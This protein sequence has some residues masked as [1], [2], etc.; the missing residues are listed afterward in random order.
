M[1]ELAPLITVLTQ[2]LDW[3]RARITFLAQLLVAVIRVRT[4]N[5]TEM[6]TAF[7]GLPTTVSSYRRIQ[8]FF[9]AFVIAP[10]I[11]PTLVVRL[12][13][14]TLTSRTTGYEPPVVRIDPSN[15]HAV[16]VL[17]VLYALS[18]AAIIPGTGAIV[19][20]HYETSADVV[21]S[22]L[23]LLR[24][25]RL[26]AITN[27]AL[28]VSGDNGM[29]STDARS[30]E[31]VSVTAERVVH[32]NSLVHTRTNERATWHRA[33]TAVCTYI[34]EDKKALPQVSTPPG[35][36]EPTTGVCWLFGLFLMGIYLKRRSL[37]D[38]LR[39]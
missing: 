35:V 14:V 9:Q 39:K 15:P 37:N 4:V 12:T 36:P 13:A 20:V 22:S 21:G 38:M 1:T 18:G 6:A 27:R 17:I 10:T 16:D 34:G 28:S 30:I 5:L 32:V 23:L 26:S 31:N 11:I 29:V 3:H 8:R 7:C 19:T 2:E 25:P 24:E 33:N